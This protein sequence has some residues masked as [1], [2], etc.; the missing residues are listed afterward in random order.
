M[1]CN[2]FQHQDQANAEALYAQECTHMNN[3]YFFMPRFKKK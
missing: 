3:M 2:P 1:E